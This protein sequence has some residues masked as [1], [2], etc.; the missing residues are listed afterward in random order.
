MGHLDTSFGLL[1]DIDGVI[2]RGHKLLPTARE[3]F[4]LLTNE[5]GKFWVPTIFVTNA[6]NS[7]RENKAKQLSDWLDVEVRLGVV[8]CGTTFTASLQIRASVDVKPRFL[9]TGLCATCVKN[10]I[11][12]SSPDC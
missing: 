6:G 2:V 4:R 11:V 8:R 3:A 1:F 5:E 7:L 9:L 12:I 10:S